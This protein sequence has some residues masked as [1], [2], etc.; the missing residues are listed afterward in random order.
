MMVMKNL[1]RYP[2]VYY[3]LLFIGFSI[4]LGMRLSGA[5]L[6]ILAKDLDPSGALVG[7][8]VSAWFLARVFIELPS[9]LISDRI[10]RRRLFMVG[11]ALSAVGSLLCALASSIY[12]LIVGR[13][14]WGFGAALFFSNNTAILL[15]LFE[16]DQRGQAVGTF[17]GIEF[18]GS[19]IGAPIGALLAEFTGYFFVFYI[20]FGMISFS[21]LLTFVS[22]EL[23]TIGAAPGHDAPPKPSLVESLKSLMQWGLFDGV[24][25]TVFPL[26]LH[27]T[28][29]F[30]VSLIG[31]VTAARTGGFTLAT[32]LSGHLSTRI[33]RKTTILLGLVIE[34]ICISAYTLVDSLGIF[35]SLGFVDGL[36]AGLVSAL[37]I[38]LSYIVKPEFRGISIG[39]FRT[40]MDV[41]GIIGPVVFMDIAT[42][43][44]IQ[45]PF[46]GGTLVLFIMAGL[47]FT[48]KQ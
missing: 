34:A 16:P 35:I 27:E 42:H 21:C 11:I 40:F 13:A 30:D 36:G 31:L 32:I 3:E 10:G 15:D 48:M 12:F 6:P 7:Y 47:L 43:I 22:K 25:S 28:V 18:I 17:Q 46:F 44:T 1:R 41:G 5:F 39:F 19:L 4:F 9:G 45:A 23:K 29:G 26:Y 8:V 38:L 2:R 37:T 33:G 20:T 24:M 14:L